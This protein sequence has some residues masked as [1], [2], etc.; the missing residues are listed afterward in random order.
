[1][2]KPIAHQVKATAAVASIAFLIAS[3]AALP[4]DYLAVAQ[5]PGGLDLQVLDRA[6]SCNGGPGAFV[7]REGQK[8]DQTCNVKITKK[9]V[10]V[11]FAAYGKR[12]F[13]PKEQFTEPIR[14]P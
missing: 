3:S 10:T 14:Q 8:I 13:I 11:L 9:G 5:L 6:L 7:F 1:M 2:K 4:A 12:V